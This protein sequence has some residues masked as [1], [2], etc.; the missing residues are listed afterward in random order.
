VSSDIVGED[1]LS[2]L[3]VTAAYWLVRRYRRRDGWAG[4][5]TPHGKLLITVLGGLSPNSS[6][7]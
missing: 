2:S 7:I 5:T 3:S 1:F 6:A 4:T